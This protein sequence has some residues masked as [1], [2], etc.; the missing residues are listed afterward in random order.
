MLYEFENIADTEYTK[1]DIFS[2]VE[3]QYLVTKIKI[4]NLLHKEPIVQNQQ[5]IRL[6]VTVSYGCRLCVR[7]S[8]VI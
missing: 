1:H 6:V 7:N 5:V 3:S 8:M 4:N 2:E